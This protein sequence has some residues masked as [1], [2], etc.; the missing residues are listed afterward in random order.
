MDACA[1]QYCTR[2]FRIGFA[3]A[4]RMAVDHLVGLQLDLIHCGWGSRLPVNPWKSKDY[5]SSSIEIA[6]SS[7][8]IRQTPIHYCGSHHMG[9]RIAGRNAGSCPVPLR[10]STK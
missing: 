9:Q 4:I 7:R 5:F 2:S 3:H 10:I 8:R 1:E 6:V